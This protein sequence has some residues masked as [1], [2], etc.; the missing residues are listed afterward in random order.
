MNDNEID[1]RFDELRI[2]AK[3]EV[4][5]DDFWIIKTAI[6]GIKD[7]VYNQALAEVEKMIKNIIIN[8]D[9]ITEESYRKAYF[10]YKEELN[11]YLEELKQKLKE[12]RDAK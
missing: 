10:Y 4:S 8:A 6:K 7:D 5:N 2:N 9:G 3:I 1:K 12:K 11:Q